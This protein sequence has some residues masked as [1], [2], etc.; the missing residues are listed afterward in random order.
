VT[1]A[2]KITLAIDMMGGDNAP[3]MCIEG[4][5]LAAQKDAD[6]NFLLF[7]DE[8]KIVPHM[9]K[10]INYTLIHTPDYVHGT[11]SPIH[12]LRSGKN[13]SMRLAIDAVKHEQA[14]GIVSAGN[15][16]ALMAIS[17]F[18]LK[19]LKNIDRPAIAG[20]MPSLEDDIVMLDMGA[21]SECS[22]KH[23]VE[24]AIMGDA[25][26]RVML[27]KSSPTI[28][29]LNIGSEDLK[30]NSTIKEAAQTLNDLPEKLNFIGFVEGND[31]IE[32]ATDVIVADGFT[33]NIALKTA[34]GTA[35]LC[36]EYTKRG[37]ENNIFSKLGYLLAK[38]S[39]KKVFDNLDPR[40]HNG[41]MFLGLNSIVVKSHG[42]ADKIAFQNAIKVAAKLARSE[43]N[44]DIKQHIDAN[45]R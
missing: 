12:A 8:S 41:A 1:K 38:R 33:G 42:S 20:I 39:L 14:D 28:G 27:K 6:I 37:F 2:G 45:L 35:K 17:R 13:T 36:R 18:V 43:I 4:I 25:F 40:H 11:D 31:I 10:G 44:N 34:E 7:G 9:G 32:G 15:T 16:G 5:K 21:N 22:S 23:L 19:T 3:I 29:L 24:F 30:G 26:A